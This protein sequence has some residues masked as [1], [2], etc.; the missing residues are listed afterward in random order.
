MDARQIEINRAN[1]KRN[2]YQ[3]IAEVLKFYEPMVYMKFQQING[4]PDNEAIQILGDAL[5]SLR[6]RV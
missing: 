4:T 5:E 2:A 6:G 3:A 1:K